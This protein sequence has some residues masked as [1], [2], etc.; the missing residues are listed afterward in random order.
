V[1]VLALLVL[2]VALPL[3]VGV[4]LLV[5]PRPVLLVDEPGQ[6]ESQLVQTEP[7]PVVTVEATYPGANARVVADVI[8]A[9]I[10]E[11]V[12]GVEK[13]LY[14][15]SQCTNDGNYVLQVAFEDGVDLNLAQVLVQNRVSLAMPL[16]P[17][18]VKQTGVT[19]RKKSPVVLG[20]V[21]LSSPEGRYDA[22]YLSNYATVQI[23]DE[24]V[25][26][27]GVGD[28]TGLG[29]RDYGLRIRLDSG[30]MAARNLTA[31][32]VVQALQAL[33]VQV[34][35]PIVQPPGAKRPD[36]EFP[37]INPGKL[38]D[39]KQVETIVLKTTPEGRL[40]YLKDVATVELGARSSDR[41]ALWNGKPVV[42][43]VLYPTGQDR[44]AE[45]GRSLRNVLERLRANR[46]AG[47]DL[48]L[49]FDFLPNAKAPNRPA[50]PAFLVLDPTLPDGIA[51]E[52]TRDPGT[53]RGASAGG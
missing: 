2:G 20:I 6:P 4:Y 35:G 26:L 46:P 50:N 21:L 5:R 33:N 25:R 47:M 3:A 9:P 28:V 52:R 10:E 45:L 51:A 7:R 30:K 40:V 39:W 19:V 22:L 8:A 14:L 17:D 11:Q 38:T 42:G 18:A 34:G 32:N 16:F 48:D 43:L 53:V 31:S 23:K 37:A 29:Q 44:S 12:N 13:M 24:L 41:F 27:P 1:A 49:A 36:V 15:F